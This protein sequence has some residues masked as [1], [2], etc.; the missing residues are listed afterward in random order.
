MATNK[1]AKQIERDTKYLKFLM[2]VYVKT[3]QAYTR[4]S[5]SNLCI[6]HKVD[7]VVATALMEI[8]WLA[9]MKGTPSYYWRGPVPNEDMAEQ[10]Q[11]KISRVKQVRIVNMKST[12]APLSPSGKKLIPILRPLTSATRTVKAGASER[13]LKLLEHLYLTLGDKQTIINI[14]ETL[15]TFRVSKVVPKILRQLDV[16]EKGPKQHYQYIGVMPTQEFA[17]H[18]LRQVNLSVNGNKEAAAKGEP[19]GWIPERF[20]HLVEPKT[21]I[22][23]EVKVKVEEQPA[24]NNFKPV[25]VVPVQRSDKDIKKSIALKL[26][27]LGEL[28]EADKLLTEIL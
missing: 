19:K 10:I 26:L 14:N 18:V 28:E 11:I 5:I 25:D 3:S 12:E 9:K 1:T 7:T 16:L 6:Q 2:D 17:D 15:S 22:K 13:Y 20:K 24:H 27:K 4:I 23:K 21:E 8:G